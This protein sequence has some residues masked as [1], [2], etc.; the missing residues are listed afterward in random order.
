MTE[1]IPQHAISAAN[2]T[3][4]A[5]KCSASGASA[6]IPMPIPSTNTN[7]AI[8]SLRSTRSFHRNARPAKIP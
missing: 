5:P 4:P 2:P 7:H 3:A 1:P 6:T 8:M